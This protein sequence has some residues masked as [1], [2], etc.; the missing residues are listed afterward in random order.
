MSLTN[1][2][3][4]GSAIQLIIRLVQRSLGLI[5][6]AILARLLTPEDFGIVAIASLLVFFFQI[7]S[8]TGSRQFI[9]QKTTLTKEDTDSAWTFNLIIKSIIWILFLLT[10]PFNSDY[11]QNSD[12]N[13]ILIAISLILP[14]SALSNPGLWLDQKAINYT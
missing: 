14:I 9:I 3:I 11:Y 8:E 5:S 4:K 7:M 12:L 10:I 1:T 13:R 2:I 6:M